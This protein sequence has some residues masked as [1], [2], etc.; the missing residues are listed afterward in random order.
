MRPYQCG[1]SLVGWGGS[2][3]NVREGLDE[4]TPVEN[5]VENLVERR[6]ARRAPLALGSARRVQP[7]KVDR[8]PAL[9]QIRE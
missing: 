2:E 3:G 5:L 9:A 8:L 7:R 4:W 6:F 1:I